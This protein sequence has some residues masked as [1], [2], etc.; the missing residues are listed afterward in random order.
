MAEADDIALVRQMTD[1]HDDDIWSDEAIA[2]LIDDNGIDSTVLRIWREKAAR[3]STLVDVS[4]AGA[5][6]SMSQAFEHAQKMVDYWAG[7]VGG[8]PS[9]RARVH[10]IDRT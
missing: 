5:R 8:T 6:R 4:E 9:G 10:K 1:E 7:A 3:Y 2:A